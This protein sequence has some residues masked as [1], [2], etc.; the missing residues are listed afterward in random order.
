MSTYNSKRF[1][2]YQNKVDAIVDLLEK[3]MQR[4]F[5]V[6][7]NFE[8]IKSGTPGKVRKRII[9]FINF[10]ILVSTCRSA[11]GF[12]AAPDSLLHYWTLNA[13]YGYGALG[14]FMSGIITLFTP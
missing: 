3:N 13:Y 10:L 7:T 6:S 4:D 8:S 11:I 9:I 5:I 12:V 2:V 1:F 14:R